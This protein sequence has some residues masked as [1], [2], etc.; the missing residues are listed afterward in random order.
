MQLYCKPIAGAL[1][2]LAAHLDGD[3]TPAGA[4]G[5]GVVILPYTGADPVSDLLGK[6]LPE[7]DLAAYAAARRFAVETGG[8]AVNGAPVATDRGSQAM[9]ANA[10]SYVTA[11][12]AASVS[13]KSPAGFITLSA[14]QVKEVGLAIGAHVQACFAAEDTIDAGIHASPPTVTT[15]AQ[16]DAAF[17]AVTA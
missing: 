10:L 13:Y 15:L 16:I 3:A 5:E 12:G 6:P 2:V 14:D 8:I 9:I 4:Y 1:I 7:V 11:S 17:A